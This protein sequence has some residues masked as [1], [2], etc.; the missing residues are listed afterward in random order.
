MSFYGQHNRGMKVPVNAYHKLSV[1]GISDVQTQNDVGEGG[2]TM[3]M[4]LS[5]QNSLRGI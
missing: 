1:T 3:A 2:P 4:G 5:E